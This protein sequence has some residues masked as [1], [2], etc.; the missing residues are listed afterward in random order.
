MIMVKRFNPLYSLIVFVIVLVA[1]LLFCHSED[2]VEANGN[3]WLRTTPSNPERRELVKVLK[4]ASMGDRTVILTTLNQAWSGPGSVIDL[5]LESFRIGEGTEGLLNHLVIVAMDRQAFD[6]C[7]SIHPHCFSLTTPGVDF[8]AEKV[9]M[10][11]DYLKLMWRRI[12]FLRLVL[13]L[14]YNFVFTDADVMWFRNPFRHLGEDITIACD[15]YMG[16][17]E[18]TSN[19]ANGGFKYVKSNTMTI[20]FYKYWHMARVLYPNSHDQYVFEIIKHAK[21]VKRLGLQI[22]YLDTAYFGGFCQPSKNMSKVCTMHANC[23][24]GIERRLHDLRLVLDDWKNFSAL[25]QQEKS[26]IGSSSSPW[27][28]PNKCK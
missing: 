27:R 5:F 12:Y 6:Q 7:K 18:D 13:E 9:F 2:P 14:G 11:P 24:V 19:R 21:I 22:N 25:S 26:L 1:C 23:C 20:E 28:A 8:A 10:T 4:K 15:F 16:N 17:P 3:S